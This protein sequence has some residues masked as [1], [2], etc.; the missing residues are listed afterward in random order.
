M[1]SYPAWTLA[2]LLVKFSG[3]FTA[4]SFAKFVAL[5]TGWVLC[6]GQHTISH[7][8]Q[9]VGAV[10]GERHHAAWY[11]FFSEGRWDPDVLWAT[12][13]R[14]CVLLVRDRDVLLAL[15]DT[16]CARSGPQ[17]WG[18]GMH[19]DAVVSNYGRGA[20]RRVVSFAFGHNWV[21]A[22]VVVPLP[23][24]PLK[25]V[26]IPVLV[27]LYRNKKSCGAEPYRKRT[28]LAAEMLETLGGWL[29]AGKR[30]VVIGD[31]EYTCRN[32]AR[33]LPRDAVLV[34][35]LCMDAAL[36]AEPG[37]YCGRGRRRKKG[38]RLPNPQQLCTD[39]SA[40][41]QRRRLV[42]YGRQV[43]ILVQ[44]CLCLWYHVT[45]TKLVR[46]VV[47]RDPKGRID[48]RAFVST[49]SKMSA[50]EVLTVFSRR[51]EEEVLHRNAKQF[52][53][54][55]DPQNGW[56]RRPRG[57]RRDTTRPGAEPHDERG[58]RAV[59]RTVPFVLIT[60]ALVVLSYLGTGDPA[61][62]VQRARLARPW[63]RQKTDPSF[64]DMLTAA[65]RSLWHGQTFGEPA[66]RRPPPEMRD[67][68]LELLLA[69]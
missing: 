67:A 47:T 55:K 68:L 25:T 53:G 17:V 43:E 16:L 11:R 48:D 59:L 9:F 69:G 41:W 60:Y 38:E 15:D 44:S 2:D 6:T 21:I 58:R 24:N 63:H 57:Q 3:A 23:W 66:H 27:R 18:G 30:L 36:F 56:W 52:L 14:L 22:S 5:T 51:W 46:V 64:A 45:G 62:D 34:G 54:L 13:F 33:G 37:P 35:R 19:H 65:R 1:H 12:L 31:A 42:L 7:V 40:R 10:W 26:A 29:P 61:G 39:Q 8:I 20:G 4:P 32:V 28:E 50:D 49:D